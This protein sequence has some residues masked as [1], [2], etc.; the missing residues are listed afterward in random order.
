MTRI[1]GGQLIDLGLHRLHRFSLRFDR[2]LRGRDLLFL[3]S[4]FL[5]L[6][7]QRLELF[8]LLV[9]LRLLLFQHLHELVEADTGRR[10]GIG[11]FFRLFFC[12]LGIIGGRFVFNFSEKFNAS[13]RGEVGGFGIGSGSTLT[14]NI[15]AMAEYKLAP[16]VGLAAGFRYRDLDWSKGSGLDKLEYDLDIYGPII[17]VSIHF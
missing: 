10:R 7:L 12:R 13:F 6:F 2:R 14:W 3:L 8:F 15:T 5:L 17:G 4:D 16:N 9:Q 11:R 1:D